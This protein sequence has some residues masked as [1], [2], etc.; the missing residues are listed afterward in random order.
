M[1]L[2][3]EDVKD[4]AIQMLTKTIEMLEG[5]ALGQGDVIFSPDHATAT[6]LTG[7]RGRLD[8][9]QNRSRVMIVVSERKSVVDD[10]AM[11][12]DAWRTA[13]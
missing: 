11:M 5:E 6:L 10:A 13:Q 2:T 3:N 7:S 12:L 4:L 9:E 1:A 8:E